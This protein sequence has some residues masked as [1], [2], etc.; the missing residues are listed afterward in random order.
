MRLRSCGVD[1]LVFS[2]KTVFRYTELIENSIAEM[3]CQCCHIYG[4]EFMANA[5][6]LWM[7]IYATLM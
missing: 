1:H 6:V 2:S 7:L 5:T 3:L 4:P